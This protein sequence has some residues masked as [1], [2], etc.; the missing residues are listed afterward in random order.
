MKKT[1][2]ASLISAALATSAP[3]VAGVSE[4]LAAMKARIAQL[5]SQLAAQQA[6]LAK[7]EVTDQTGGFAENVSVSGTLELLATHAEAADNNSSSDIAVDTFELAVEAEINDKLSIATLIEYNGDEGDIELS[8]A[9]AVIGNDTS[10]AILTAGLAPIPVAAINDAGWTSPLTDDFFDITEG[11][12][13]VSFG[14]ETIAAD[15]YAFNNDDGDSINSLGLNLSVTATEGFTLGA[16]YVSDLSD[17][18][19][20]DLVDGNEADGAWRVN[21]MAEL[22]P[23]AFSAEYLELDGTNTDPTFLALNAAYKAELATFYLGWSEIDDTD[24]DGAAD[25]ERTV[26]GL[27]R[28][29]SEGTSIA[30]EFVR[31][32]DTE[33]SETDTVNLVLISEF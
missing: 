12:A 28:E 25:A 8:E 10:P 30:A 2:L 6:T 3:A 16:G 13:M 11:M 29:I 24:A 21:A 19:M 27:E 14:G 4:E 7:Q 23:A 17:A 20:A 26:L 5:E 22:G 9:F 33:G 31:D 18:D 15:I 32:E 1:V